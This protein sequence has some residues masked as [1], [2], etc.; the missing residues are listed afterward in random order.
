MRYFL[1][2]PHEA[3]VRR[4]R[5]DLAAAG[6]DCQV[7][8]PD[9][10]DPEDD[11]RSC[12]VS[13]KARY[14]IDPLHARRRVLDALAQRRGGSCHGF[15]VDRGSQTAWHLDPE[16]AAFEPHRDAPVVEIPVKRHLLG[17]RGTLRVDATNLSLHWDDGRSEVVPL[18]SLHAVSRLLYLPFHE[19]YVLWFG[20][21]P[22]RR[23]LRF[24]VVGRWRDTLVEA[25]DGAW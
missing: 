4:I 23:L 5:A 8:D 12:T 20:P 15:M 25:L 6:T 10:N 7:L 2:A 22:E 19:R 9:P 3:A 13:E 14:D 1:E 18:E 24:L 17:G 21:E 16:H 11:E